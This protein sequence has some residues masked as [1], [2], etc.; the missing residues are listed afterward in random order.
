M[1][2]QGETTSKQF[3]SE[4]HFSPEVLRRMSP[5]ERELIMH[6]VRDDGMDL[7]QAMKYRPSAPRRSGIASFLSRK[8][9]S[10]QR[11]VR[12]QTTQAE[13]E[14]M[15]DW[16]DDNFEW[17]ETDISLSTDEGLCW[18]QSLGIVSKEYRANDLNPQQKLAVENLMYK[19]QSKRVD[20]SAISSGEYVDS[21]IESEI[22]S[23]V[24]L[25]PP[26]NT[27]D[28]KAQQKALQ[29]LPPE[30][31]PELDAEE[32]DE[33]DLEPD[34][35]SVTP[36]HS[37]K[38]SDKVPSP[39]AIQ[40]EYQKPKAPGIT[41]KQLASVAKRLNMAWEHAIDAKRANKNLFREMKALLLLSRTRLQAE[42]VSLRRENEALRKSIS[43]R[44][45]PETRR[46]MHALSVEKELTHKLQGII[47]DR[48]LKIGELTK[49]VHSQNE[50]LAV[51][52]TA[53]DITSTFES[54][55]YTMHSLS[56]N[57]SVLSM[58]PASSVR[59]PSVSS[60][61]SR[62][63]S[64]TPYEG[65]SSTSARAAAAA[66]SSTPSSAGRTHKHLSMTPLHSSLQHMASAPQ[67]PSREGS[68]AGSE[69]GSYT[70]SLSAASVNVVL[71]NGRHR[72][73]AHPRLHGIRPSPQRSE[74]VHESLL[75]HKERLDS[76]LTARGVPTNGRDQLWKTASLR[77][78]DSIQSRA[79][80]S[81]IEPTSPVA[82]AT[83]PPSPS[84][85]G[86]TAADAFHVV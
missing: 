30:P 49:M 79:S 81:R 14:A 16:A 50:E 73:S 48:D 29:D 83:W 33:E 75:A 78:T 25:L 62:H 60:I 72:G 69:A 80:M 26:K 43:T 46:V 71:Q 3:K 18:L 67:S 57:G 77:A 47:D 38:R 55:R 56:R 21:D 20:A 37:P 15:G 12:Q 2:R 74:S 64:F 10:P 76:V 11:P 61:T 85:D 22:Q 40:T 17:D 4:K 27:L 70:S 53:K 6:A 65:H 59:S 34:R 35:R 19:L 82:A 1:M 86:E 84:K 8:A 31:H 44:C 5:S 42:V 28:R 68:I 52:R 39:V 58:S 13:L 9:P 7:D 36:V 32:E 41:A 54:R 24:S 63:S 45:L 23:V 51:L 66:A